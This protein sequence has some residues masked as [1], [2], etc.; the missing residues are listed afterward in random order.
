MK[1][2]QQIS[3]DMLTQRDFVLSW[4]GG[5]PLKPPEGFPDVTVQTGEVSK[6]V[7]YVHQLRVSCSESTSIATIV[8]KKED[9]LI[10]CSV[11]SGP[12]RFHD[13]SHP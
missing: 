13:G 10:V 11:Q 7:T 6:Y 5:A 12:R 4:H 9:P 8:V 1:V 3:A 2:S